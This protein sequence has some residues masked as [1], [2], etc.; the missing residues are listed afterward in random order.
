MT[1]DASYIAVLIL[2]LLSTARFAVVGRAVLFPILL[3]GLWTAVHVVFFGEPR[4]HLPVLAAI[5]P[6]AGTTVVW[7]AE[8]VWTFSGMVLNHSEVAQTA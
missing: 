3:M 7:M 8:R 5:I 1:L 2:A 4:Y 6:M